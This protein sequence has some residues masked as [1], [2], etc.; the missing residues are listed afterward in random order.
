MNIL[1]TGGA[2]FIGSNFLLSMVPRYPMHTFINADILSYAANINNLNSIAE[3]SNYKFEHVDIANNEAVF[4]LFEKHKPELVLHFAAES[5]VDRSIVDPHIFLRTNI[6]G[7]YNLLEAC[8]AYWAPGNG[9]FH[10]VGTDEVYGSLG[11]SGL[12]SESSKY[13]PSSPYSASKASSDHLVRAWARTFGLNI[14]ITNCCNNYGPYQ[15]PEKLIPLM[16][17]NLIERKP[18]PIYGKGKNVRSWIYVTD[19]CDAIWSVIQ[20]GRSGETY[21]V[22]GGNEYKNIDVINMLIECISEE[23]GTNIN[24][25]MRLIVYVSDRP[26]HDLRYAIDSTKIEKELGWYPKESFKSGLCKT[27]RWYLNNQAWCNEV[28]TGKC[29]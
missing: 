9:L 7:T 17:S 29:Q 13:D 20:N 1:V 10:H 22:G 4:K 25:L 19:H 26:G 8:R 12:F 6:E 24:E 3:A 27:V 2:G 16:I 28:K 11:Y 15:F 18:L 5:H 21:N 14:R 23:I